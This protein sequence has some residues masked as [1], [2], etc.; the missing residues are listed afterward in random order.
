MRAIAMVL[1]GLALVGCESV[2]IPGAVEDTSLE[3]ELTAPSR[4]VPSLSVI[5]D[6]FDGSTIV[7]QD[8]VSSSSSYAEGWHTLGF[9]WHQKTPDIVFVTA[10]T[11]SVAAITDLAF[12]ADGELISR[13]K[14][15]SAI[16]DYGSL[17]TRR[18]AMTWQDFLKIANAKSVK[19]KLVRIN[20]YTVS[21][22]G[23]ENSG[24]VVNSTIAPFVAKVLELR[25]S[26]GTVR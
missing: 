18:F 12:N 25:S 11:N 26:G 20:D 8:A 1:L 5:K 19:M 7:Q 6:E 2:P 23:T 22:F 24:A 3:P 17:S 14:P 10:G 13:I 21:S 16:T 9:E 15:D 4:H